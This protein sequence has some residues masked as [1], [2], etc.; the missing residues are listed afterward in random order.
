MICIGV[1]VI[2]LES[3]D[4]NQFLLMK[5]WPTAEA[6][7]LSSQ[8]E[9]KRAFH[10]EI[11]YEYIVG[12]KKYLG[13][14]DMGVPGFGTKA[15]RLNVAS[16]NVAQNPVGKTITVHYDPQDPVFSQLRIVPMYTAFLLL[17]IGSMLLGAGLW[18]VLTAY[19][20]KK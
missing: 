19:V 2:V 11:I 10:P 13:T 9:G 3:R 14:T 20:R 1:T 16:T 7:I 6:I 5:H 4:I 17:S 12:G 8:V 18:G 15:N